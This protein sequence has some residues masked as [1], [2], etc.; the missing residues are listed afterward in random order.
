MSLRMIG[1]THQA[2][3]L[4]VRQQL[5][6][7][8]RQSRA[9]LDRWHHQFSDSEFVLLS[10]C[11]RV[12]L[13]AAGN[14]ES[15]SPSGDALIEA[16]LGFHEVPRAQVEGQLLTL[17]DDAVVRHLYRVTASLESMVVGEPQI[18]SQVKKAYEMA[19]ESGSTG[20][21]TH[22]FFQSALRTA[23]RVAGEQEQADGREDQPSGVVVVARG[24]LS[25]P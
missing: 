4:D 5:A 24:H 3:G 1:C 8:Q 25:A 7:D 21:L 19:R 12:E 10:T 14:G 23:R 11:N 18:L 2:T 9:A 15:L 17:H 6:F 22:R 20:P 13:Y 16:L